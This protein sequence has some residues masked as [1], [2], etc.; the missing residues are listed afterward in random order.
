MALGPVE[1]LVFSFPGNQFNGAIIPELERL[2]ASGTITVIDGVFVTRDDAGDVAFLEFEQLGEN[3]D[4]ARLAGVL[5]QIE[6]LISDEDILELADGLAPGDS[7]AILVFE[8]TWA[9]PFRDAIVESGGIL[10]GE[11]RLPGLAVDEL[12]DEL[13]AL[14]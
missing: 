2:T 11:M 9:K 14:D 6:S 3:H 7:E 12:L 5:D 1:V 10:S 4:A 8:H 13:A